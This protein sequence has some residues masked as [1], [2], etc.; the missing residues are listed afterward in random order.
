MLFISEFWSN[1][2]GA[3]NNWNWFVHVHGWCNRADKKMAPGS[4]CYKDM[5]PFVAMVSMECINVGLNT[6][7]KAATLTGMSYHVFVVYSYAVAALVLLPSRF[8]CGNRSLTLR[9]PLI[10]WDLGF[11]N[12]L[13]L[14]LLVL[15]SLSGT[16][17]EGF[18][19]WISPSNSKS[20]CL[21]WPGTPCSIFFFVVN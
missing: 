15:N 21:D 19:H 10:S 12:S 5:L 8:L 14:N 13:V 6:L 20:S 1:W 2:L 9:S 18:L 7:F 3:I 11:L 4:Y 16:D 17:Q